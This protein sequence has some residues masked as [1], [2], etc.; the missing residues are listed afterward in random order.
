MSSSIENTK[1]ASQRIR[2][3]RKVKLS[4]KWVLASIFVISGAYHFWRL[5]FDREFDLWVLPWP[6]AVIYL[7]GGL[8]LMLGIML[9]FRAM[10]VIAAWTLLLLL[11]VNTPAHL[12]FVINSEWE[13][14][15]DTLF[16]WARLAV[17]FFL[18]AWT[19]WYTR[20]TR[21]NPVLPAVATNPVKTNAPTAATV[22][23]A[24]PDTA[25][26]QQRNRRTGDRRTKDRRTRS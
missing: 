18:I 20:T 19:F 26:T 17:Q 7:S 5:G 10:Q 12:Y 15:S 9:F 14:D 6:Y 21:R 25:D 13:L 3:I 1:A 22:A 8:E 24:A 23:P 11:I 2:T 4:L 16:A